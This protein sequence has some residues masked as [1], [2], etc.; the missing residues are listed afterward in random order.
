[1]PGLRPAICL[2]PEMVQ[3]LG[4]GPVLLRQMPQEQRET[5]TG[6]TTPSIADDP[7]QMTV[8]WL[9]TRRAARERMA[10]FL[11]RAGKAYSAT[12]NYD[13]GP[14][15]RSNV[16]ALSPWVRHRLITEDEVIRHVLA[17]HA[18]AAAEK[19]IQEVF[20]RSY[21]KGWLEQHPAVW[22][23]YKTDR[24]RLIAQLDRDTALE[25]AYCRAIGGNSG[26]ECLDC[27]VNEL[28]QTGYL[29]NHARMW[30]ASIWI[31]TLDLPWQL[32]ADFFY[33]HLLD[34][35]TA[36]NTLSWRWV[37]GLHT[38]GKTYL[39]RAS[40]IAK[41]TNGRFDPAGQLA[42]TASEC[43]EAGEAA[44][45]PFRLR[46]FEAVTEPFGMLVTEEDC[47][48]DSLGLPFAP[49][50]ALGLLATNGRSPLPV[51]G[52]VNNFAKGAVEDGLS[53][54]PC[55]A[56]CREADDWPA[57]LADWALTNGLKTIVTARAPTGPVA[58][59]LHA[60][61]PGLNNAGLRLVEMARCYDT[62]VWP[63]A[64]KGYFNLKKRVPGFISELGLGSG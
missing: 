6:M 61:R 13:L 57:A 15:D 3:G 1:M 26:I 35:D 41:Y 28:V 7:A 5:Q 27:W 16:S 56:D 33:R 24:D 53:R 39:A 47:S 60:A 10:A 12:R 32:G 51:S 59:R 58:E 44:L 52:I 62:V 2:A 63:H 48:P 20:W 23:A 17:Q 31:F 64:T 45:V 54:C 18:P 8:R 50:A 43:T 29:H 36:S 46:P 38:K 9:P 30:F 37:A 14:D 25:S 34:G 19:Y 4:R 21:F 40:N 22:T 42:V 11:P 55:P 49:S